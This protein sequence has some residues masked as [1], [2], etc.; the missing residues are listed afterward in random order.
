M[1]ST[2]LP[3]VGLELMVTSVKLTVTVPVT[4][5]SGALIVDS[6]ESVSGTEKVSVLTVREF[7]MAKRGLVPESAGRVTVNADDDV[8]GADD[9]VVGSVTSVVRTLPVRVIRAVSVLAVSNT[10]EGE[11]K[12]GS[13]LYLLLSF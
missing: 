13:V 4:E 9:D 1:T 10:R 7:A 6:S 11:V 5:K 3:S 8:V 2:L 12:R